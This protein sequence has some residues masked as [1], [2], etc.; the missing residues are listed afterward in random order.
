[1]THAYAATVVALIQPIERARDELIEVQRV[2][3]VY[4][5]HPLYEKP[6]DELLVTAH[7]VNS[8]IATTT[9]AVEALT[10]LQRRLGNTVPTKEP[11]L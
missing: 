5:E 1:M 2:L 7:N 11:S 10:N 3:S 4:A 6:C 8:A 9:E